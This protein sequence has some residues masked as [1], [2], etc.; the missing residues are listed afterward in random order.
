[1]NYNEVQMVVPV[2]PGEFQEMIPPAIPR[3]RDD[4]CG[5]TIRLELLYLARRTVAPGLL[6][7]ALAPLETKDSIMSCLPDRAPQRSGRAKR[8][9]TA[10]AA[11]VK[12][13]TRASQAYERQQDGLNAIGGTHA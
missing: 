2:N 4:E 6:Y 7:T 10:A 9:A 8:V 5:V 12:A 3:L 11:G 13:F 1:M